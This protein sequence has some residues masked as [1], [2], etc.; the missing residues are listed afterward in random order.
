MAKYK[1]YIELAEAM[2]S[3]ELN[4]HYYLMLDK[5]GTENSLCY[6]DEKAS[7]RENEEK[8]EECSN[9]FEGVDDPLTM[10]RSMGIRAEW[11]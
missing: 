1:N 6:Y 8:Q 7:D 10:F 5:G 11:C 3:G 4:E 2:K 9:L